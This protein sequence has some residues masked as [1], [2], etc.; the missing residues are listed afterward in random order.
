MNCCPRLF[1]KKVCP[2]ELLVCP[3]PP[4]CCTVAPGSCQFGE[5]WTTAKVV[6]RRP[7]S[8]DSILLTV[9]LPDASLPLN[10]ATCACIL[11]RV[12]DAVRPY[13]PVSTNARI[14]SFDLIVKI[15][16]GGLSLKLKTC[17]FLDCKHSPQNLK[18]QYPFFV[19]DPSCRN[20]F[21]E[22]AAPRNLICL[23]AGTGVAPILQALHAVL[24]NAQDK[25]K[26]TFIYAN[27]TQA[28]IL[29]KDT[30][31]DWSRHNTQLSLTYVLSRETKTNDDNILYDQR[32]NKHLLEKLL[33]KPHSNPLVFVCGPP[34]FYDDICGNRHTS[35][36]S[37]A[38]HD[39]GYTHVYKF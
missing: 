16:E 28:D 1:P 25:T 17:D 20:S 6:E 24:G 35:V 11:V 37:G 38:L 19:S 21:D 3:E 34:A 9:A 23:A 2:K 14:G 27:K 5:D 10:L 31:D 4:V 22:P 18:I 15:Y 39:L 7:L 26:V 32:I 33:P 36:I 13:T 8:S 29:A 12:D 30:L